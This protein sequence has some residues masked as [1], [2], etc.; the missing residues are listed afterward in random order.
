MRYKNVPKTKGHAGGIA[1]KNRRSRERG[2]CPESGV[3]SIFE[4]QTGLIMKTWK[5]RRIIN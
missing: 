5:K 2:M 3:L 4:C 1:T